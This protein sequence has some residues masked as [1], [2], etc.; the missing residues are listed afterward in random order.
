MRKLQ[1]T[2]PAEGADLAIVQ[3]F[4]DEHAEN[5]LAAQTGGATVCWKE[6]GKNTKTTAGYELSPVVTESSLV[7]PAE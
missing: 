1:M 6:V 4:V 5:I 2:P 7:T 3:E